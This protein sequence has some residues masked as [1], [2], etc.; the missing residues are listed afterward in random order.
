MQIYIHTLVFYNGFT[1]KFFTIYANLGEMSV[2]DKVLLPPHSMIWV[3][4]VS[5]FRPNPPKLCLAAT[6][7]LLVFWTWQKRYAW[8][9]D[10]VFAGHQHTLPRGCLWTLVWLLWAGHYSLKIRGSVD[11]WGTPQQTGQGSDTAFQTVTIW[12]LSVRQLLNHFSVTP[13]VRS[14]S[15][16]ESWA[17]QSKALER[18]VDTTMIGFGFPFPWG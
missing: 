12:T 15:S 7:P 18:S 16:K 9:T 14:F 8:N 10:S 11:P 5:I 13:K 17:T 2:R 1:D 4:L 6:I 3:F